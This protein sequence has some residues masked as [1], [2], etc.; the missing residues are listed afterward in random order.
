MVRIVMVRFGFGR[1]RRGNDVVMMII[2][3]MD[4][5]GIVGVIVVVELL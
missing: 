1:R 3:D 4:R 5:V 2:G